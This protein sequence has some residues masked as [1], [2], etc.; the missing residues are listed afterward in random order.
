ME[1]AICEGVTWTCHPT[2]FVVIPTN[3]CSKNYLAVAYVSDGKRAMSEL[4][5]NARSYNKL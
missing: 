2:F 3:L 4:Q 5:D 1:H